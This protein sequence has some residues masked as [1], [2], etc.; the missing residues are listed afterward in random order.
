MTELLWMLP[1]VLLL[2][3]AAEFAARWWVRQRSGYYVFPPGLRLDVRPDPAVSPKLEQRVRFDVNRDGE[4]GDEPPRSAEGVYRIL[5]AGGSAPEGYLLDQ[6]TSWPGAL[7]RLLERPPNLERLGARRV[8]VGNV[9][10]SGAGSQMVDCILERV[11]PRYQRLQ[12][13]AI[14][15]GVSDISHWLEAGAPPAAPPPPRTSEIFKCHPEERFGWHPRRLALTRLLLRVCTR[16]LRLVEVHERAGGW[17]PKARAMRAA[18]SELRT[19]VPD[20]APM[21]DHFERH[22]RRAVDRA[23]RHADRVLVVRQPW[24]DADYTPEEAARMWHAGAG[25]PWRQDVETY[26][27]L[28]VFSDLMAMIDA[29][30]AAVATALG[31]EQLDLMP[32]LE[33]SLNTYYD[34]F[35]LTPAGSRAVAAAVAAPILHQPVASSVL[36]LLETV[37]AADSL[38]QRVRRQVVVRPDAAR[39][40]GAREGGRWLSEQGDRAGVLG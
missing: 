19:T 9:A 11:L 37:A 20:P 4:R 10:R 1:A 33:R 30:A 13:I 35:H 8:H 17:M 39:A 21:L 12:L 23:K 29:R 14:F 34:C 28:E 40:A 26:Y 36:D 31:V 27:S 22:L 16:W 2:L 24:L 5:V 32:I 25:A 6:D 7:Q 3:A 15:V 18:A 38:V